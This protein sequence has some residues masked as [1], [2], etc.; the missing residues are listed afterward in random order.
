M[1]RILSLSAALIGIAVV[2]SPLD[3]SSLAL[4]QERK[5]ECGR[6]QDCALDAFKGGEIRPLPEV[7]VVARQK[8]PGEVVKVELERE[9]G[10]WV[11]E[12]KILTPSGKRRKIEINAR[13][14]AVIKID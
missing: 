7:L 4:A 2:L 9:D 1:M 10:I 5:A 8:L 12:I 6:E 14:L 13:T 3:L 11:Y